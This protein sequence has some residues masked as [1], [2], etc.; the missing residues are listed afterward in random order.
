MLQS[1]VFAVAA[2]ERLVDGPA[3]RAMIHD[4]AI[5]SCHAL[6]VGSLATAQTGDG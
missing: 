2:A 4:A 6:T 5:I 3:H 1:D